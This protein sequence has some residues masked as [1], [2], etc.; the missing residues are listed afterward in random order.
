VIATESPRQ[1]ALEALETVGREFGV[2]EHVRAVEAAQDWEP[3]AVAMLAEGL[4][5]LLIEIRPRTGVAGR[6]GARP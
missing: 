5:A 2:S 4:A 1:R 6:K 3:L